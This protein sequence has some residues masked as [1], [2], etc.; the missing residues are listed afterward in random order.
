MSPAAISSDAGPTALLLLARALGIALAPDA[1]A[2]QLGHQPP[3]LTLA[4]LAS[5]AR[6]LGLRARTLRGAPTTL[7]ELPLPVLAA[8]QDGRLLL[9]AGWRGDEALVQAPGQPP[10]VLRADEFLAA[11]TGELL[12]LGR[13][14]RDDGGRAGW[15]WPGLLAHRQA[16]LGVLGASFF[17][18]LLGLLTPLFFQVV[19]DKVLVHQQQ[20]T[21]DVL[22]LGLLLV[23]VSEAL[24]GGLRSSLL[25][26]TAGRLDV[27][28]SGQVLRHLFHLP[29]AWFQTRRTGDTVAAVRELEQLRT[30]LTGPALTLA[31]D[32]IFALGALA[33]LL[34]WQATL[35]AVVLVAVLAQAALV[36]FSA[37]PLRALL[38]TRYDRQA[39]AQ[40][41]LVEAV[42]GYATLKAAACEHSE[43]RRWDELQVA[44]TIAGQRLQRAASL[45]AQLSGL[46]QKVGTLVTLWLGARMVMAG[47]LT[48]GELVGFNLVAARLTQPVLRLAQCWQEFQQLR[49]SLRRLDGILQVLPEPAPSASA[50]S[51]TLGGRIRFEGVSFRYRPQGPDVLEDLSL[52]L[53]PGTVLG[54]VGVSGS[55]KSTLA[56][57]LQR[58]YAPQR[59][60]ILLDETDLA[61]FNPQA[62]R[63]QIGVVPQDARLFRRSV[64]ANIA[65][66]APGLAQAQI[67]IAARLAGAHE[68]ILQL[69]QGYDTL[70]GEQG[71]DLSG[72]QRQRLALARALVTA[73]RLLVLDEATSALDVETEAAFTSRLLQ[74]ARGRTVLIIAH[75]LSAVCR[76]DQIVV[77][78][79]GR[80]V[81]QGTHAELLR[82]GGRYAQLWALQLRGAHGMAA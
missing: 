12:L 59:G 5:A 39:D 55:G 20:T 16:L 66:A 68:F 78:A 10:R 27:L 48:V 23:C 46:L 40:S 64:A 8:M 24:L 32:L 52:E 54:V 57:L 43:L 63:R 75:R 80:L 62:L 33:L 7:T 28:W 2:T 3:P 56:S 76:A 69:P 29:L 58:L 13:G 61:H 15:F 82:R 1:L 42:N 17:L 22:C 79:D 30:F 71:L 38:E 35:A 50:A 19:I 36:A 44:A 70:L 11:W 51:P 49:V 72:G 34:A 18:Q 25:T 77:M 21:L 81:E 4:A 47:G 67:E 60:R 41:F 9:L 14:T 26:H 53:A 37:P 45:L 74:L 31:L 73:P 65:L 6:Q